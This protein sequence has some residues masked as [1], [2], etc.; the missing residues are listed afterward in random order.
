MTPKTKV[1]PLHTSY[2]IACTDY[3]RFSSTHDSIVW[4]AGALSSPLR[5]EGLSPS[6]LC[7]ITVR[8]ILT[9]KCA[10]VLLLLPSQLTR[11]PA[12]LAGLGLLQEALTTARDLESPHTSW[13]AL[14][15]ETRTPESN[16]F[17]IA[18]NY[19][20]CLWKYL[21]HVTCRGCLSW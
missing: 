13:N 16:G 9:S 10:L 20:N 15:F 18:S 6:L 5:V 3:F 17:Q 12:G 19:L 14:W 8:W 21:R 11:S 1:A 2:Q 7:R 4:L